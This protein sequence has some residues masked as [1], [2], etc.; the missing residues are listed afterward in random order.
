[1]AWR[2]DWF[3]STLFAIYSLHL[4][5]SFLLVWAH[6]ETT[7]QVLFYYCRIKT[8]KPNLS[9]SRWSTIWKV[10]LFFFFNCPC[11][12]STTQQKTSLDYFS[13]C[14]IPPYFLMMIFYCTGDR[15]SSELCVLPTPNISVVTNKSL[16]AFSLKFRKWYCKEEI[17]EYKVDSF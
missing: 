8:I 11:N 17:Q 16:P 5:V 6:E 4:R 15:T 12:F 10:G 14:H 13:L 9:S 2:E 3:I 7:C 1:M